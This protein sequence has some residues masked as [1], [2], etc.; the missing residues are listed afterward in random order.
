[1][2]ERSI[3][4]AGSDAD[5]VRE[6]AALRAE[7]AELRASRRRVALA[8]D[9]ERRE[10]ER[11]FH[12]GV[13]QQLI[14]LAADLELAAASA[15]TDTATFGALLDDVRRDLTQTIEAA[16]AFADR[17]YPPILDAGGLRAALRAAAVT[18]SV[19]LR[20]EVLVGRTC[21]AEIAAVAYFC[22]LDVLARVDP[23]TE[24]AITVR[25]GPDA[26]TFEIATDQEL[27]TT[28]VLL[29][30]VAALAGRLAS[31]REPDGT[32]RLTG[33]LPLAG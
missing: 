29:D 27:E 8:A 23:G 19:P 6:L 10:I 22:C 12:D 28:S 32:T 7:A 25:E 2:R 1:M 20:I 17:I 9:A 18:R 21:P 31:S 11:T 13:Q 5:D 16:R 14:G 3:L 26:V 4:E 24:V 15:E 33:S 30:R